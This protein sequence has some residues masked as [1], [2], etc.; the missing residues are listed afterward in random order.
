MKEDILTPI[1]KFFRINRRLPSYSE[2]LKIFAVASKRTVYMYVQK[3]IDEGFL[4]KV[5]KKLSPTKM[6]FSLPV[7]G[8][9]QA[10]Y[11]I[12]AEENRNYITLDEYFIEQPDNSFLLKVQGDSMINM[13]IFEGDL[14]VIERKKHFE[15]GDIVLAEIDR[16]WTLKIFNKDRKTN[17]MFLE[18]AN[19]KYPRFY[20]REEL[21]IHGIVRAVFRK[22]NRRV[23]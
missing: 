20:P 18:A 8:M 9:I 17:K 13:G 23:N 12:L 7:L 10:G 11:P 14:V 16:E 15:S 5:N 4:K 21:K 2:M 6:F 19:P 1:K 22:V 3:L